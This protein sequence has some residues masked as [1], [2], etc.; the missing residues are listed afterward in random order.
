MVL[1]GVIMIKFDGIFKGGVILS[2]LYELK[3]FIFYLG[4][5][6]KED[7]LIVF[8]EECFIEDLVD[9]VFVE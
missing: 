1:D 3:L 7:D 8:D 5:G 6:E 4:M 9:V 2:V